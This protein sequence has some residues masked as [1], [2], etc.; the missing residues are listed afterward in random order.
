MGFDALPLRIVALQ[1]A[2]QVGGAGDAVLV[3]AQRR[4]A[5]GGVRGAAGGFQ[6]HGGAVAA[7]GAAFGGVQIIA[8]PCVKGLRLGVIARRLPRQRHLV[9]TFADALGGVLI[10]GNGLVHGQGFVIISGRLQFHGPR[11]GAPIGGQQIH[12]HSYDCHGHDHNQRNDPLMQLS[13]RVAFG[14][15]F[16]S[17]AQ[18]TLLLYRKKAG[19]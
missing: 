14:H 18:N 8:Q 13:G 11:I 12:G 4:K 1:G 15:I 17:F 9:G 3:I 5:G 7:L 6:R 16:S 2:L 19:L 10:F